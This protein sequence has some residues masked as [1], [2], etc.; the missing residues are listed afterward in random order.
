VNRHPFYSQYFD[1]ETNLHYNMARDYASETGR[2]VQSD[3]IGLKGGL[4][5]YAYAALDPLRWSDSSGLAV[6]LCLRGIHGFPFGNH[7]YFYDATVA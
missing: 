6:W 4:N 5:T 3:P 1:K 2:Y 7:T